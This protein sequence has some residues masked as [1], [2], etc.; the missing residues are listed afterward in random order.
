MDDNNDG[1]AG[2][3]IADYRDDVH[4]CN[5]VEELIRL[6]ESGFL[7]G[8]SA[9]HTPRDWTGEESAAIKRAYASGECVEAIRRWFPAEADE[10]DALKRDER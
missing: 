1:L 9:E 6:R 5:T 2:R 10:A 4:Q 7:V 3:R 8:G